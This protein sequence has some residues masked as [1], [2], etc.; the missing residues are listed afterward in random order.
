MREV[1]EGR[2]RLARE[3]GDRSSGGGLKSVRERVNGCVGM[4]RLRRTLTDK[5]GFSRGV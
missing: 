2:V 3:G 5:A 1:E 4:G